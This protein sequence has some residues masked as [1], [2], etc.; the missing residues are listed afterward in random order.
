MST[1]FNNT[2]LRMQNE[3]F[4]VFRNLPKPFRFDP[5]YQEGG[6]K[7]LSGNT[8]SFWLCSRLQVLLN[9]TGNYGVL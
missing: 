8:L 6:L 1:G 5:L 4:F 9:M 3:E 2:G 7:M